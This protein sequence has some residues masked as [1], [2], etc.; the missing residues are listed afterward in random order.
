MRR[1]SSSLKWSSAKKSP[2]RHWRRLATGQRSRGRGRT[3][4]PAFS[5]RVD[6]QT[7]PKLLNSSV[8][9]GAISLRHYAPEAT[10][11]FLLL[12]PALAAGARKVDA[13][14]DI[15]LDQTEAEVLGDDFSDD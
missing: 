8:T 15:G 13:M 6:L 10:A 11:P 9:A 5:A 14:N 4:A 12:L 7:G 1:P 2:T 3:F